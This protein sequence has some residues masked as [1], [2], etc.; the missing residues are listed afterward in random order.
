[1]KAY[2][3]LDAHSK[4]SV[5]VIANAQ[6]EV[7]GRGDVPTTPA[8][9]ATLRTEHQVAAGTP[10]ALESGTVAFFV[11]RQLAALEL[12][13]V[14]IDAH[15]VR[16]KA[17]RPQHKSDRRDAQELCEGL[18]RGT[19]RT[20][21]HVPPPP[22]AALREVLSRR[23]HFV[24]MQTAEILAAKRLLRADGLGHL[25]RCLRSDV[26]WTKLHATVAERPELARY[27][28]LHH[29]VWRA[30]HAQVLALDDQLAPTAAPCGDALRR[31]QTI[32]GVGPIVALTALA[33]FS[34]ATRF[35]SAKHAASYAGLVPST[36]QSGDRD[37][38]GRIT[39]RGSAELRA[40]ACESAH[41]ARNVRHPLHPYLSALTARR[42]HKVAIVAV[43]HRLCRIMY[44]ML[45]DGTDF[46]VAQLG[47]EIGPFTRTTKRYYR[48]KP[49][50]RR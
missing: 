13:P 17:Y 48:L 37:A 7:I 2:V 21:I 26:G 41:H 9:L 15:E 5:F 47:V 22:I 31:L 45:R 1:M 43:A 27:I 24:R 36:Y 39:K 3:G 18:R 40:M 10:V 28:E 23:R 8:G 4:R 34:D 30:A 49:V 44:A 46:D 25:S 11:A 33:V 14:V 35:P 12:A 29:A 6:G 32:P 38:H 42:G 16:L 19:Y 20:R 50:R